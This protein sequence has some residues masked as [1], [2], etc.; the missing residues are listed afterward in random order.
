MLFRHRWTGSP[1]PTVGREV[2][3]FG[4]APDRVCRVP[5]RNVSGRDLLWETSAITG[6]AVGSCIKLPCS[7]TPPFHRYAARGVTVCFLWHFPFPSRCIVTEPGRYPV[8]CPMVFGLSSAL[9]A[10]R[11]P[12]LLWMLWE[13]SNFECRISNYSIFVVRHSKFA[14]C[15]PFSIPSFASLSAC[16][17]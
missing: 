16:L 12:G 10:P 1:S 4:L 15:F 6:R 9:L 13:Q 2:F 5:S 14:V 8:S 11:L 7:A 17:F 3:L